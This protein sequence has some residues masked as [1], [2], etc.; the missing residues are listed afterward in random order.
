[1]QAAHFEVELDR[2]LPT[3]IPLRRVLISKAAL[4]IALIEEANQ[5][6]NLTGSSMRVRLP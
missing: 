3:T 2:F 5:Q 6:F 1:V 4:H